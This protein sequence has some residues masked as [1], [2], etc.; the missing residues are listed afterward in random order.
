[1]TR[2][3]VGLVLVWVDMI[4]LRLYVDSVSAVGKVGAR[5]KALE[6]CDVMK[7]PA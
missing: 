2:T 6:L 5:I 7:A 3:G 4:G 1:M